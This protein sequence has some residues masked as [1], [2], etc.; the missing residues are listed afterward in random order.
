MHRTTSGGSCGGR[1]P[2]A[3]QAAVIRAGMSPGG[4]NTG[5]SGS[6][7]ARSGGSPRRRG[8]QRVQAGPAGAG[9]G[10]HGL[11]QQP[12][13]H[14]VAQVP[15]RA[16]DARFVAEVGGPAGLGEHRLIQLH[17]DQGPRAAGDVGEVAARGRHGD[18]G[19]RG[20][21]RADRDHGQRGGQ[22]GLAGGVGPQVADGSPGWRSGGNSRGGMPARSISPGGPGLGPDVV[23]LRGGCV[24]DLGAGLARSA[25]S[26]AGR[27]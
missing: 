4:R 2:I 26:R 14:H 25:S 11:L 21:M 15:D 20:V 3:R 1:W 19:G 9:P 12:Q 5:S 13:A 17:P 16:V 8:Q 27:G 18:H 24:G 6:I 7:T 23:E 22:P 10:P